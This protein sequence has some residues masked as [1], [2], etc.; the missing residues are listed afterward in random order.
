MGIKNPEEVYQERMIGLQERQLEA[1]TRIP[2]TEGAQVMGL[3]KTPDSDL[4]ELGAYALDPDP[5]IEE[6]KSQLRGYRV[7]EIEVRGE[8]KKVKQE[9][10]KP[11][12][13]DDGINYCVG[14]MRLYSSK[15]FTLT[16]YSGKEGEGIKIIKK[17]SYIESVKIAATLMANRHGWQIDPVKRS[18]ISNHLSDYLFSSMCRSLDMQTAAKYWN[19]QKGITHI[20]QQ[21]SG[22]EDKKRSLLG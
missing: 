22:V 7:V 9:I 18:T 5:D 4:R 14:I 21:L 12:M 20:N 10:G 16:N 6:F 15:T 1:Q 8:I 3:M 11:A 17:I 2:A 19:T 13:T